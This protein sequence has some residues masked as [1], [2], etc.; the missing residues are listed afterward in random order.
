MAKIYAYRCDANRAS[1]ASSNL[2]E[3]QALS[4]MAMDSYD[5]FLMPGVT[6]LTVPKNCSAPE[7]IEP[8]IMIMLNLGRVVGTVSSNKACDD[9]VADLYP[10]FTTQE[11][12]GNDFFEQVAEYEFIW[13]EE[14]EELRASYNYRL[15]DDALAHFL[16]ATIVITPKE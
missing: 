10:L 3:F 4:H 16:D 13:I 11:S 1:G 15:F 14:D 5:R 7:L 9:R 12:H 6:Y 8:F 2:P